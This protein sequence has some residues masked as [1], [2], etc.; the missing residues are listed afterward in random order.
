MVTTPKLPSGAK[1][2]NMMSMTESLKQFYD[3]GVLDVGHMHA[4]SDGSVV[5]QPANVQLSAAY[6]RLT[7]VDIESRI[8]EIGST[9]VIAYHDRCFEVAVVNNDKASGNDRVFLSTYSSAITTNP[10]N[11]YELA[12]EGALNPEQRI[13]YVSSPGNGGSS[14]LTEQEAK[15]FRK[16][17]RVTRTEDG[18]DE[19][20][21]TMQALA[22]ALTREEIEPTQ[23]SGDSFG[24]VLNS[25]LGVALRHN[26]VKSMYQNVRPQLVDKS[27]PGMASGMLLKEMIINARKN[28]NLKLDKWAVDERLQDLVRNRIPKVYGHRGNRL[29]VGQLATIACGLSK[30]PNA[31][32]PFVA[33]SAAFLRNNPEAKMTVVVAERD[34][35]HGAHLDTER[36]QFIAG[37]LA[38]HGE[39]PPSVVILPGLSHAYYT[40]LPGLADALKKSALAV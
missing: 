8:D 6:A 36:L 3:G 34:P 12:L 21:P 10:G 4:E 14:F 18:V 27:L 39:L 16:Y 2:S 24:A 11:A 31:G 37:V 23:I 38:K 29:A 13:V 20:I 33:D 28:A 35:L 9:K 15:Y 17:G 40:Y 5:A 25:G 32:D 1:R 7:A 22:A 30:G 19:A 26:R